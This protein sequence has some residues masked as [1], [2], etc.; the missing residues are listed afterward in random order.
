MDQ[1]ADPDNSRSRAQLARLR[2][3]HPTLGALMILVLGVALGLV[4]ATPT[5]Q[6]NSPDRSEGVFVLA[7]SVLGGASLVG[8]PMLLW[9]RRRRPRHRFGPGRFFWFAH[10]TAA[11]LLWPPIVIGR[12]SSARAGNAPLID[13]SVPEICFYYGTPLMAVYMTAALLAGGWL[14]PRLRGRR[15]RPSPLPW[16]ERFGLLLGFSWAITGLYVLSM[17]YRGKFR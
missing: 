16:R 13:P 12:R 11:W 5:L 6:G 2:G 7:V 9:E 14:R 15:R 1:P 17:I 8:V 4:L 3:Q 10:G